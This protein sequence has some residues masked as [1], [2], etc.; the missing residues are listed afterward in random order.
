MTRGRPRIR[1]D[2]YW[3]EYRRR[4]SHKYYHSHG[5]GETRRLRREA[6]VQYKL[7]RGCDICGYRDHVEALSFFHRGGACWLFC[8][9]C[10]STMSADRMPCCYHTL[11]YLLRQQPVGDVQYANTPKCSTL[12]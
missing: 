8:R 11:D 9:N 7:A 10:Q 3:R 1:T 2:E 12:V 5:E 6:L 4:Q